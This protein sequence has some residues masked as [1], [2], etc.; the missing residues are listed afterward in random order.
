MMDLFPVGPDNEDE[1]REPD[2]GLM[3]LFGLR[4]KV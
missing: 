4:E 2:N 1:N 3:A